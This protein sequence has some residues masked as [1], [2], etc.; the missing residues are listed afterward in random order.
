MDIVNQNDPARFEPIALSD[1]S[2]V[3]AEFIRGNE[4]REES[5]QSEAQLEQDF[6]HR[7]QQ[8]QYEYVNIRNESQLIE[9]LRVHLERLNHIRFSDNDW[10]RF[11]N[12][13][14]V[15]PNA[16]T[17]EKTNLIQKDHIH[18]FQLEGDDS[19]KNI[20]LLDKQHVHNNRLQVINQYEVAADARQGIRASRY[21]VT[22]L[23]NGLPLVHV[24]LKRRGVELRE[25][26]NQISRYQRESFTGLFDYVQIFVIS[27]G[28]QTK[29]YSNA[30]RQGMRNEQ[31]GSSKNKNAIRDKNFNI[32]AK[33]CN[34]IRYEITQITKREDVSN[35]F[36]RFMLTDGLVK[37]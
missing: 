19:P 4:V 37:A 3:I 14:L 17:I 23:V 11:F 27:N 22:I 20:Y 7:L 1:E 33:E 8:Q 5:Y 29:Y 32:M 13:I 30:I 9:N 36:L 26:F 31:N 35:D 28:A 18:S 34:T 12:Q 6:I 15:R 2:T 24:E 25:A 21:D 16:S 10:Q